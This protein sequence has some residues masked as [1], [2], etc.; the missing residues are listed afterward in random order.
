M[1]TRTTALLTTYNEEHFCLAKICGFTKQFI[2]LEKIGEPLATYQVLAATLLLGGL[3]FIFRLR[4]LTWPLA[5]P[6]P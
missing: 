6:S 1:I 4:G 5:Q 2:T 3:T